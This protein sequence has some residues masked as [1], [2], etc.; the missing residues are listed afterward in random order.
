MWVIRVLGWS[1]IAG[2]VAKIYQS[3]RLNLKTVKE[4]TVPID[5]FGITKLLKNKC[6]AVG[7][8]DF[9]ENLLVR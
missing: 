3:R 8:A 7:A 9:L 6:A 1:L 4:S 2:N 5:A